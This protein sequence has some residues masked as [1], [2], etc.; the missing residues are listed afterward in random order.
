[1]ELTEEDRKRIGREFGWPLGA[2]VVGGRMALLHGF[3]KS[4]HSH[5]RECAETR[6]VPNPNR[7]A[8]VGN[9]GTGLRP[10]R[11]GFDGAARI[12]EFG[13]QTCLIGVLSSQIF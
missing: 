6:A 12:A 11:S 13:A 3:I 8:S 5:R 1:M 2:C 10:E 4:G 7:P 9:E